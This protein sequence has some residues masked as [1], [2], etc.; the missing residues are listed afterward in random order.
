M[1]WNPAVLVAAA[2]RAGMLCQ[3]VYQ[4]AGA[5][6]AFQVSFLQPETLVLGDQRQVSDF[7]IEYPTAAL[8]AQLREGDQVRITDLQGATAT[9]RANAHARKVGTGYFSRCDLALVTTP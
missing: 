4:P 5:A 1:A 9:Y 6:V 2:G 3:A 8:P 7:E